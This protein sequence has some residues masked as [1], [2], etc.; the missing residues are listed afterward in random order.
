MSASNIVH[1]C[2]CKL[3][4]AVSGMGSAISWLL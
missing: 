2:A 1:F 3:K 4:I